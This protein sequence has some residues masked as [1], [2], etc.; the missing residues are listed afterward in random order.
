MENNKW[1][2]GRCGIDGSNVQLFN[3]YSVKYKIKNDTEEQLQ[4]V[5]V[6]CECKN[7]DKV[8]EYIIDY[9]GENV[10]VIGIVEFDPNNPY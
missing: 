8:R 3:L 1:C 2:W 10:D 4:L 9:M 7:M 5:P 6:K